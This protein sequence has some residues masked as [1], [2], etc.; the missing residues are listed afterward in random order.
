MVDSYASHPLVNYPVGYDTPMFVAV[1]YDGDASFIRVRLYEGSD[2]TGTLVA[3]IVNR[4]GVPA[5]LPAGTVFGFTSSTA[6]FAQINWI[7]DLKI[8]TD[9]G[10]NGAPATPGA[11]FT[12]Q[13][14][15]GAP[16]YAASLATN[17]SGGFVSDGAAFT[18]TFA[19]PKTGVNVTT[20]A[21]PDFSGAANS[22][23][24]FEGTGFGVGNST[25]GRFDRGESFT[26]T[27]THAFV[28]QQIKFRELSGDEVLHIQ[29]TQGGAAQQQLFN[30]TT[31]PQVF[32]GVHADA[33]TPVTIT[34]ASPTSS[35]LTGRLRV[36]QI[37]AALLH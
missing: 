23:F 3:D 33:N 20:P 8:T 19:N 28:I 30:I 16:W 24:G 13:S 15:T 35:P 5:S 1:D 14:W 7:N 6:S 11:T 18:M 10:V 21:A 37:S 22:Y 31:Y 2:D 25:T 29:W 26:L 17:F 36:E 34:N 12:I 32:T 4:V 9:N 27:A